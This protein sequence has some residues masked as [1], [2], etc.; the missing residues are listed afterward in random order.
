MV[1]WEP[2]AL[3]VA[4]DNGMPFR[5][6]SVHPTLASAQRAFKRAQRSNNPGWRIIGLLGR[7]GLCNYHGDPCL[8]NFQ[9][10]AKRKEGRV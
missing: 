10:I 1:K 2:F 6:V 9:A 7:D 3:V 4:F 5:V 8:I